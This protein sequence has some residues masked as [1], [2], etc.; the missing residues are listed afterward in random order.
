MSCKL[1][2]KIPNEQTLEKMIIEEEQIRNSKEY[3]DKCTE[4]KDIPNGWLTVT[5]Q[6][7]TDLVKRYGFTDEMSCDV[8]L[9]RLRRASTIYP[10]NKIFKEV[11]VYIRNNKAQEGYL[12]EGDIAPNIILHTIDT[13]KIELKDLLQDNKITLLIGSSLT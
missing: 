5:G 12:K 3:I 8:A 7:Q 10:N 9:N 13:N 11:P 4:V 2:I 1:K 6:M